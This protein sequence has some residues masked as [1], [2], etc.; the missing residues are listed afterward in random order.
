MDLFAG[1]RLGAGPDVDPALELEHRER[2]HG[3]AGLVETDLVQ[4]LR[5]FPWASES[6]SSG[7]APSS[8]LMSRPSMA[9]HAAPMVRKNRALGAGAGLVLDR[10][11]EPRNNCE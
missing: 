8:I 9:R 2:H 10:L 1:L 7:I 4:G 11:G 3:D 6:T 5:G